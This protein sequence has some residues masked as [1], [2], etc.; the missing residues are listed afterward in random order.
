MTENNNEQREEYREVAL[1]NLK[2]NYLTN[3]ASASFNEGEA[4]RK[5]GSILSSLYGETIE[6]APSQEN[7]DLLFKSDLLKGESSLS[8]QRLMAKAQSIIL[9]SIQSIKVNDVFELIGSDKELKNDYQGKYFIEVSD[10]EKQ[11]LLN[12]Y[13]TTMLNEKAEAF[14]ERERKIKRND[15]EAKF[16][17]AP[18]EQ[19]RGN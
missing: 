19:P 8:K 3:L 14:L 1:R 9:D 6:K 5:Y 4:S 2:D 13:L 10:E 7:Y 17:E 16:C 12:N 11:E 18:Q 15:L